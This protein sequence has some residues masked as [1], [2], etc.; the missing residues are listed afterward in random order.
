MVTA[1]GRASRAARAARASTVVS[2][3]AIVAVV[4]RGKA[5]RV[6][7]SAHGGGLWRL[8]KGRCL[9]MTRV[10]VHVRTER[11][12]AGMQSGANGLVANVA[13][14]VATIGRELATV[15]VWQGASR[16]SAHTGIV[17]VQ[18]L[19]GSLIGGCTYGRARNCL[20]CGD[21]IG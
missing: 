4:V 6:G 12:S 14:A 2:I 21:I 3:G 11:G 17:V 10:L 13:D 1:T 15:A 16:N 7:D 19:L 5:L 8:G 9:K 20:E 18:M